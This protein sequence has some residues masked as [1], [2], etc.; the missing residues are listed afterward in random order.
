MRRKKNINPPQRVTSYVVLGYKSAYGMSVTSHNRGVSYIFHLA[1]LP[2]H[3][4]SGAGS[5][6]VSFA[7]FVFLIFPI[8]SKMA[9]MYVKLTY[10]EL[11]QKQQIPKPRQKET[12]RTRKDSTVRQSKII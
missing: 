1:K 9:N 6:L 5:S 12:D 4:R 3:S 7:I 8:T 11:V 10:Q 2:G